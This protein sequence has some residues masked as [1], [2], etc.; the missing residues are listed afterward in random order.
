M[1]HCSPFKF[2]TGST[3]ARIAKDNCTS[4]SVFL[5]S[6]HTYVKTQATRKNARH[7]AKCCSPGGSN[8]TLS[9]TIYSHYHGHR[10]SDLSFKVRNAGLNASHLHVP[11]LA[12]TPEVMITK[13]QKELSL[14]YLQPQ[15]QEPP[16]R[17]R[18]WPEVR[19]TTPWSAVRQ[20]ALPSSQH[21]EHLSVH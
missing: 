18:D 9:T 12:E 6:L 20:L 4:V 2:K 10:Y 11:N 3:I 16:E 8:P 17:S 1:S 7:C 14:P 19:A 13:H 5:T 15:T 21:S